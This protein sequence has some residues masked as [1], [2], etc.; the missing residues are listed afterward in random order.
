MASINLKLSYGYV[1]L[2]ARREMSLHEQDK[3]FFW[4]NSRF[5]THFPKEAR[6]GGPRTGS[7]VKTQVLL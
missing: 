7:V 5:L 6:V 3:E 4:A 1:R 2:W